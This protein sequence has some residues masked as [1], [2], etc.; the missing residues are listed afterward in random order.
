M[1]GITN[2]FTNNYYAKKKHEIIE[3]I[4]TRKKENKNYGVCC[5]NQMLILENTSEYSCEFCGELKPIR[6]ICISHNEVYSNKS[7][8]NKNCLKKLD[9]KEN[10]IPEIKIHEDDARKIGSAI[11]KYE[12]Y[13]NF[14]VNDIRKILKSNNLTKY[15]PACGYLVQLMTN[16]KIPEFSVEENM[17]INKTYKDV[18]AEYNKENGNMVNYH[19]FI[20][21]IIESLYQET[22][23]EKIKQLSKFIYTQKCDTIIKLDKIYKR[24]CQRLGL[25]FY[26]SKHFSY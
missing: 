21:K 8:V 15:N 6:E 12:N 17:I 4:Y 5:N 11:S 19:F 14:T 18:V 26:K 1:L 9:W 16:N 24:I 25:R 20:Y 2:R 3:F 23:P 7:N 13:K 22:Y 10:L